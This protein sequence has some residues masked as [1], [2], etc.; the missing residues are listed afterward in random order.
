VEFTGAC[1]ILLCFSRPPTL[2]RVLLACAVPNQPTIRA[3]RALGAERIAQARGLRLYNGEPVDHELRVIE[4][5]KLSRKHLAE[6]ALA[7]LGI[8]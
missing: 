4:N 1:A 6:V 5:T 8:T 7:A 3:A 2:R